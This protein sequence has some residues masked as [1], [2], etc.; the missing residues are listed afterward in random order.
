MKKLPTS[1]LAARK[2]RALIS[3]NSLILDIGSGA[4][5]HASFFEEA[6]HTVHTVDYARSVYWQETQ[7]TPTFIGNFMDIDVDSPTYDVVWASHVLE[8][9]P[10]TQQFLK[11]VHRIIKPGGVAAVTVP[12]MKTELVGGH[13]S[14]WTPGLLAYHMVLAGFDCRSAPLK[15]YRYNISIIAKKPKV[16]VTLPPLDWDSGDINRVS[17]WMPKGLD[18]ERADVGLDINVNW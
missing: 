5:A 17:A 4:G 18:R 8:H 14:L 1:D 6:G 16:P 9:Q 2:L 7:F 15:R 3:P 12:P 10:N 13:L 11:K